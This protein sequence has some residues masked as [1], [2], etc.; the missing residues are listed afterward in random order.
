MVNMVGT[1]TRTILV[2]EDETGLRETLAEICAI[3]GHEVITTGNGEEALRILRDEPVDVLILDLHIP[4]IDGL[5]VLASFDPPPPVVIVYS[6][7]EYYSPARVGEMTG[8]KVFRALR[9]P[10]PPRQLVATLNE[11]IAALD[12]LD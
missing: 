7:F 8:S 6:A 12:T 9:K 11:A 10:V 2:V 4:G 3:E 5:E 1:D